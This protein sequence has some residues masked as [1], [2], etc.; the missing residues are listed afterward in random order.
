MTKLD[1][2]IGGLSRILPFSC[3]VRLCRTEGRGK[4]ARAQ[5]RHLLQEC[6]S[7]PQSRADCRGK[8]GNFFEGPRISECI[9]ECMR[10]QCKTVP[11]Y[12]HCVFLHT[13]Q[14][15]LQCMQTGE[16]RGIA[17][18]CLRQRCKLDVSQDPMS[19]RL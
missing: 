10:A 9:S 5:C 19:T 6:Q 16:G 3:R 1:S 11:A 12:E 14:D 2:D 8:C 18:T 4:Y 15:V 13:V 17:E 7:N